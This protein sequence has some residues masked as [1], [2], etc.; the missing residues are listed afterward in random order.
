[1]TA[2][3]IEEDGVLGELEGRLK[4]VSPDNLDTL[5]RSATVGVP[6]KAF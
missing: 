1:M 6:V 5:Y 4:G 3:D 2:E